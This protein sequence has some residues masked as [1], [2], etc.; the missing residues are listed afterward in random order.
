MNDV[1]ED[2][3][4]GVGRF[5]AVLPRLMLIALFFG[6]AWCVSAALSLAVHGAIAGWRDMRSLVEGAEDA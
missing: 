5:L 3:S 6:P 4:A 2:G 1:V